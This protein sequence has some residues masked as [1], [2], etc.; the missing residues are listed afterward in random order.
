MRPLLILGL[1]LSVTL[2]APVRSRSADAAVTAGPTR[3]AV[4]KPTRPKPPKTPVDELLRTALA[5]VLK[6]PREAIVPRQ[7]PVLLRKDGPHVTARVIPPEADRG[8]A[9]VTARQ[10]EE[11]ASP[12]RTEHYYLTLRLRS[13]TG[14]RA[15]VDV[16]LLP[17]VA[18]GD[19]AMC[20]WSVEREY[21][22]TATGWAF[23]RVV[24]ES[25]M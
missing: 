14:Q 6:E 16:T 11:L 12:G 23:E 17:A 15:I 1:T 5:E 22:R 7:G 24:S 9:L 8:I 10:L 18:K 3:P 25:V 20:C 13:M 2:A 4:P 21:R 19:I